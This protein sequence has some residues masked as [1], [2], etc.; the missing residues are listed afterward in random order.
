M[1][2]FKLHFIFASWKCTHLVPF[3]HYIRTTLLQL[4]SYFH[5][6]AVHVPLNTKNGSHGQIYR[7][8]QHSA[9]GDIFTPNPFIPDLALANEAS[10]TC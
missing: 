5:R 1:G 10:S 9:L 2:F 8:K 4:K 3:M 6:D 7:Q